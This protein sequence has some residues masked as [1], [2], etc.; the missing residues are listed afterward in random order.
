MDLADIESR[1]RAVQLIM[2]MEHVFVV[3]E[4]GPLHN[5]LVSAIVAEDAAES[6][7]SVR[8]A[9][10]ADE[11]KAIFEATA[12]VLKIR[13]NRLKQELEASLG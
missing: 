10:D 1:L 4:R 7:R 8:F 11:S 9:F 13:Y 2:Q 5:A 12:E 6:E 3:L